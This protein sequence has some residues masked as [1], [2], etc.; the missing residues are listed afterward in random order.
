[1][2]KLEEYKRQLT[3][4]K[5]HLTVM[6]LFENDFALSKKEQELATDAI[7][8]KMIVILKYIRNHAE[9]NKED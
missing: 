7:L 4:L 1:M 5:N 2:S 3:V 9:D 6:L 8:D